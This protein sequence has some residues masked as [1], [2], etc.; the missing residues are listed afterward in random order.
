[1]RPKGGD[2]YPSAK[3]FVAKYNMLKYYIGRYKTEEMCDKATDSFLKTSKFVP[4]WFVTNNMVKKLD[5]ALSSNEDKVFNNDDSSNVPFSSNEIGNLSVDLK[6][7]CL[8][9]LIL[10]KMILNLLFRLDV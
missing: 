4:N 10:T 1:M 2:A 9:I 5:D 3:Q 8:M 6:S 7:F